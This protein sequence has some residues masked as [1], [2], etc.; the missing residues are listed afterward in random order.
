MMIAALFAA[1]AVLFLSGYGVVRWLLRDAGRLWW[2]EIA[3]L[4]WLAGSGLVSVLLALGGMVARGPMLVALV[5][6]VAL[7]ICASL[8]RGARDAER[9]GWFPSGTRPWEVALT[10]LLV[11]PIGMLAWQAMRETLHWDGLLV[12]EIKARLAFQNG[13]ALPLSYYSDSAMHGWSH[14]GY[15]LYLPMLELWLYLWMGEASQFWVKALFP[16]FYLAAVSV[17]WSAG[18]RLTGRVWIGAVAAWLLLLVPRAI[19]ARAGLLQGYA[20]LPLAMLYLAAVAALLVC[21]GG[22]R[23]WLRVAAGMSALLPWV[24]Q[25]GLVLWACFALVAAWLWRREW[26]VALAIALPGLATILAWH[27]FLAAVS[28]TP[29][30]TFLPMTIETLQANLPRVPALL[31]RLGEELMAIRRWSLLWPLAA[32]APGILAVQRRRL[33]LPLTLAMIV[34]LG[35]YLVPYI[36]SALQPYEMHVETSID[37]LVLQVA[38]VAVLALALVLGGAESPKLQ[39]PM[40]LQAPSP[41]EPR[42]RSLEAWGLELGTCVSRHASAPAPSRPPHPARGDR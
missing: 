23:A 5:A 1:L 40:K 17:L 31:R 22:D 30:D 18:L 35:M 41:S 8:W 27:G 33:A 13:G 32:I 26:Y 37:R 9:P 10:L 28:L 16:F 2:P 20:D 3:G 38:P 6:V 4:A 29:P 25:E 21:A 19:G 14:P 39:T 11:L 24:K 42:R 15:P 7:A 12:W 36:F 34:P